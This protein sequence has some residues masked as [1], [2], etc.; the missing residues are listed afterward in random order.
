MRMQSDRSI[1]IITSLLIFSIIIL[2]GMGLEGYALVGK[3]L[4]S[5]FFFVV[6]LPRLSWCQLTILSLIAII[7]TIAIM[8]R[9][10]VFSESIAICI[11]IT[12]MMLVAKS[13]TFNLSEPASQWLSAG[14]AIIVTS[15]FIIPLL[16]SDNYTYYG[17]T[18]RGEYS[19]VLDA[20]FIVVGILIA[21]YL[22]TQ[23]LVVNVLAILLIYYFIPSRSLI[24]IAII[25]VWLNKINVIFRVGLMACIFAFFIWHLLQN[26]YFMNKISA[27]FLGDEQRFSAIQCGVY[28]ISKFNLSDVF[29]G[30]DISS[31][32]THTR[33]CLPDARLIESDLF[34]ISIRFG[35]F[36]LVVYLIYIV[37]VA[38]KSAIVFLVCSYGLLFGHVAFNPLML[39]PIALTIAYREKFY[40]I[41]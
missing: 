30:L 15:G 24:F 25:L 18:P 40:A 11:V 37:R 6:A 38:Q 12:C 39:I 26:D 32:R 17:T 13:N 27:M 1:I 35:I 7:A 41:K 19:S 8:R 23:R 31:F 21:N 14:V 20:S 16:G 34:D 2:L 36:P 33:E 9:N 10:S 5:F 22:S 4:F 28:V 29:F 3:I